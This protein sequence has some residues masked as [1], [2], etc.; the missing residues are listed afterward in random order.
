[1]RDLEN[2]SHQGHI[3]SNVQSYFNFKPKH[4]LINV[5]HTAKTITPYPLYHTWINEWMSESINEV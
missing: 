5:M 4:H 2:I 1:M 3:R